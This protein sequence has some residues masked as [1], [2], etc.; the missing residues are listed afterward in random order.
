MCVFEDF[1]CEFLM[2][3]VNHLPASL[4]SAIGWGD[5]AYSLDARTV[6]DKNHVKHILIDL[7]RVVF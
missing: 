5:T 6:L 2:V 7:N 1:N 4:I 3:N